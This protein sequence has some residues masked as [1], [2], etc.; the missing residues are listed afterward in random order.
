MATI[1]RF[2]TCL[3]ISF[4]LPIIFASTCYNPPLSS[5][6]AGTIQVDAYT[7]CNGIY[8]PLDFLC[9]IDPHQTNLLIASQEVSMCCRSIVV[10][11]DPP[12]A[13][14]PNGLCVNTAGTAPT[15][16]RESCTDPTWKSPICLT[17]FDI[18]SL[19]GIQLSSFRF[20]EC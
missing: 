18:C 20:Y 12:D 11:G 19:V 9:L 4:Y 17:A 16:W 6:V 10:A 14:L 8:P 13:C 5:G 1:M 7:S 2:C 3:A 15:Y